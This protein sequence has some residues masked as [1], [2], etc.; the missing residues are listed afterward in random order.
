MG[1]IKINEDGTAECKSTHPENGKPFCYVSKLKL[2]L[3]KLLQQMLN[4]ISIQKLF[5]FFLDWDDSG[6]GD[7]VGH[8][9]NLGLIRQD[10]WMFD[11]YVSHEACEG[12]VKNNYRDKIGNELH[13]E[14]Y[15]INGGEE[16]IPDEKPTSESCLNA[17]F[18]R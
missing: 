4:H 9:S 7:F 8:R 2:R 11:A 16:I 13:L 14:G 1:G 6:C 5:S 3:S 18:V 12:T 15:K 10:R 17:C